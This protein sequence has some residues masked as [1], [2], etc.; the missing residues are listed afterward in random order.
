MI[1]VLFVV[2]LLEHPPEPG[3]RELEIFQTAAVVGDPLRGGMAEVALLIKETV[4]V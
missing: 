1:L 4:P 2:A 3:E